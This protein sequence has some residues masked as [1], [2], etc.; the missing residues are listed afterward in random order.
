MR[1]LIWTAAERMELREAVEAPVPAPGEVSI[2]VEVVGICGSE[3][4]GYLGHNSL[5]VPPLTMGHEFCGRI[6]RLGGAVTDLRIGQKVVVNPLL[7]CGQ[8]VSCRKGMTQLCAKRQIVGIHRPGAFAQSVVVPRSAVVQVPDGISAYRAAL[9]EPL[10]CSLRAARRALSGHAF[11]NAI[12]IGAG[13]I[14]LLCGM[15]ARLLG[16]SAVAIADTNTERLHV[17]ASVGFTRTVNPKMTDLQAYAKAEFGDKGVDVVIDAAGFQ[18]TREAAMAL[19]NPGGTFMNIGL[20]IDHTMLPINQLIR[21]EIQLLGSFCYTAQDF[22]DAVDLL[23]G[24]RI[25]EEGWTEV[26]PLSAGAEAFA[27][28]AAGRVSRGKIFLSV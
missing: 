21:S 2:A 24:E 27:E 22:A 17:A 6:E 26:R 11:A 16:A 9:S 25:T 18:P 13:G 20:G 28:L 23:I 3:L 1:A 8:C 14:G 5:R 19:L 7:H 15:V 10:A 12:V 4:E